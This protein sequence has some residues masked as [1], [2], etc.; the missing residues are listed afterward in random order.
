GNDGVT[1]SEYGNGRTVIDSSGGMSQLPFKPMMTAGYASDLRMQGQNYLNEADRIENGTS[2]TWSTSK[3]AFSSAVTTNSSVTGN[4]S[5]SG[6]QSSFSKDQ[7]EYRGTEGSVGVSERTSTNDG[8]RIS[9]G[10]SVSNS[11]VATDT[12]G[13]DVSLGANA[14]IGTPLGD[15]VGS[16]VGVSA[17]GSVYARRENAEVS[18][19]V[20]QRGLEKFTTRGTD[21]SEDNSGRFSLGTTDSSTSSSGTFTRDSDYADTSRS[22]SASTGTESRT[23]EADERR[24]AASRY[25]E[26]GNRLVAE[27]SYAQSNGFQMS[28]DLSNLVQERYEELRRRQPELHLP[29]LANPNLSLTEMQRRD[30]G[31]TAV[32]A[33]LMS[34]LRE[35]KLSELGDVAGIGT[36]GAL[37]SNAAL[38]MPTGPGFKTVAEG[39]PGSAGA[40][41]DAPEGNVDGRPYARELGIGLK[42]GANIRNIDGDMVPAMSAVASEAQR[43]GL[44]KPV[45]TSGN[46][47]THKRGSAHYDDRGLDF[48]G[49]NI[50]VEQGRQWAEGVS[51]ALGKGYGVQFEIFPDEPN[52]NHLHVG[53]RRN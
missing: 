3:S 15:I 4:R 20:Q 11:L 39:D 21:K 36:I 10:N 18:N 19:S 49:K 25:R 12:R 7:R 13:A 2:T 52:R 50:S 42:R 40:L 31:V 33:D 24:A 1:Y 44:P 45:I 23:S 37:N 32:M 41:A 35:R 48:R 28:S 34:D 5:E 9:Q 38:G 8:L 27:A 16:E 43:L 30:Q 53:K 47:S 51:D 22:Q 17:S 26:I 6:K 29:D 14:K 46:D